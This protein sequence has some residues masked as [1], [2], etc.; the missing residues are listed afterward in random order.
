MTLT[1]SNPDLTTSGNTYFYFSGDQDER[2]IFTIFVAAGIPT[3]PAPVFDTFT[4]TSGV[5]IV[6]PLANDGNPNVTADVIE[7]A[8]G[9]AAATALGH[10]FGELALLEQEL[11][12]SARLRSST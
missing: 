4:A 2:E 7:M 10:Y 11:S 5:T 8:T 1:L 12:M 6:S 3:G 9:R